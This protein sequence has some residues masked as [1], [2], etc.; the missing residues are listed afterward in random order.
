MNLSPTMFCLCTFV[1]TTCHCAQKCDRVKHET[2]SL[3]KRMLGSERGFYFLDICTSVVFAF[4][5]VQVMLWVCFG[6]SS[7]LQLW[8]VLGMFPLSSVMRSRMTVRLVCSVFHTV[9]CSQHVTSAWFA[10]ILTMIIVACYEF[11]YK[12]FNMIFKACCVQ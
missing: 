6:H 4:S 1:K 2:K 10:L 12:K 8:F 11:M 3:M 9:N 5:W 7:F